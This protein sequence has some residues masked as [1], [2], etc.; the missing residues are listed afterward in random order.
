MDYIIV[1]PARL[2]STRLKEKLLIKIKGVEIIARTYLKCKQ[3]AKKE[4]IIV[5]TDSKKIV[6]ICQKYDAK[7][8]LTSKNCLT[9]TDRVAEVAKKIKKDIYINVQGDEPLL[10]PA[11]LKKI[12]DNSKK[13]KDT[14]L[15]G[16]ADIKNKNE[17][18]NNSIPKLVFDKNKF[19][20]YMSRAPI[21][22]SKNNIFKKSFKQVCIYS[23]PRKKL[24]EF[25]KNFKKS[26]LE[27][28][29][30]IEILRFL[31]KSEK[32]KMIKLSGKS[33]AI[34]TKFDLKK[35]KKYSID[36]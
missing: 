1:I 14:I 16:Y 28:L 9:G 12:I 30:D 27:N 34:D 20:L 11:D 21:P 31:E 32:I 13:Y 5:A 25:N 26:F 33:F 36:N 23:F 10:N 18:Y 2:H 22:N 4:N 8:I 3:V 15:N 6:D 29:E 17:Y 19:L 24:L 7:Y 35:I